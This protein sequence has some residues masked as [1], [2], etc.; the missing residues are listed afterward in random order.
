MRWGL[1]PDTGNCRLRW[2][3]S[4]HP[5]RDFE[6]MIHKMLHQGMKLYQRVE[7]NDIE[8]LAFSVSCRLTAKSESDSLFAAAAVCL[9]FLDNSDSVLGE[10]RIYVATRGCDWQN[11][12]RLHLIPAPDSFHWYDYHF[13]LRDE[14]ESLPGVQPELVKAVQVGLLGFVLGNC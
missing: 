3:H 2:Q 11:S 1:F 9:E 8:S 5:D 7:I 13:F 12:P 10:T 4:F 6:V 14:L